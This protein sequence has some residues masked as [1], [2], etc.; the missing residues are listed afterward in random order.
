MAGI[1]EMI[2]QALADGQLSGSAIE[3]SIARVVNRKAAF[4]R[5]TGPRGGRIGPEPMIP[6]SSR[7]AL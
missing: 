7:V 1:A 6:G 2:E 3:A 5:L 4:G